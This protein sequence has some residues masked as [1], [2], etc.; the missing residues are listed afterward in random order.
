MAQS[1]TSTLIGCCAL[2]VWV[3]FS[4]CGSDSQD[5]SGGG[6]GG[7]SGTGGTG[8]TSGTGGAGGTGGATGGFG[9]ATGGTAG[10]S[11]GTGGAAGGTGGAAGGASGSGGSTDPVELVVGASTAYLDSDLAVDDTHAYFSFD[12]GFTSD[13]Q[14]VRRVSVAGGSTETIGSVDNPFGIATTDSYVFFGS[15]DGLQRWSKGGGSA[16]VVATQ[17]GIDSAVADDTAVYFASAYFGS[18]VVGSFS[19][20]DGTTTTLAMVNSPAS[21]ALGGSGQLFVLD[22]GSAGNCSDVN[23]WSVPRDGSAQASQLASGQDGS[24]G[25]GADAAHVYWV[26]SCEDG[27]WRVPIDGG[28]AELFQTNDANQLTIHA[29][30]LY[31]TE[32][33]AFPTK[34]G[35]VQRVSTTGGAVETL[36]EIGNVTGFGEPDPTPDRI[37]VA[38]GFVYWT[39]PGGGVWRVAIP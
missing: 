32:P 5:E 26:A 30:F 36:A 13:P 15:H 35:F 21:L 10:A 37:A 31:W 7:T 38:G 9:G 24:S 4:G 6:T 17:T 11:G 8:G 20:T 1:R 39:N 22:V 34:G 29:G 3:P 27:I 28:T 16:E 25:L 2:L 18:G 12:P 19:L 14:A 33:A 23:V